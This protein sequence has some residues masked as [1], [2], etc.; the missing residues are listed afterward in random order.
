MNLRKDYLS[1]CQVPSQG[2]IGYFDLIECQQTCENCPPR[3]IE[4]FTK[5]RSEIDNS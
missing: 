3:F 4:P 2:Y 1:I 5:L